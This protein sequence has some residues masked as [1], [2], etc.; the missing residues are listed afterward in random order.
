MSLTVSRMNLN[1]YRH[2]CTPGCNEHSPSDGI[3]NWYLIIT[4][5]TIWTK[6]SFGKLLSSSIILSCIHKCHLKP[7][8]AESPNASDKSLFLIFFGRSGY[9][10]F[11]TKN[12]KV[13]CSLLSLTKP[14]S[15]M[16]WGCYQYHLHSM[17]KKYTQNL[18]WHDFVFLFLF[19]FSK[20][21][22]IY[23]GNASIFL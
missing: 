14:V 13:T 9:C 10:I 7:D 11:L 18:K 19:C 4:D 12:K 5:T 8:C 3:K 16:V 6:D 15:G 2:G 22:H 1:M 20:R 17:H 23:C 21:Q